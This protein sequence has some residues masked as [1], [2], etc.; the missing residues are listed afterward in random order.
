MLIGAVT[1][2]TSVTIAMQQDAE[3]PNLNQSSTDPL[4]LLKYKVGAAALFALKQSSKPA[5]FDFY[6]HQDGL[7]DL[8]LSDP[9]SRDDQED[10]RQW[11]LKV[12]VVGSVIANVFLLGLQLLAAILSK[13]L[14]LFATTADAFMD[15][16]SAVVLMIAQHYAAQENDLLY[17]TGKARYETAGIIVFATLMATLSIQIVV[18]SIQGFLAGQADIEFGTIAISCVTIAIGTKFILYMYCSALSQYSS[19]RILAQDHRNDILVNST[20]IVFGL[21]AK[22]YAWWV[23]PIGAILIAMIILR[24]WTLTGQGTGF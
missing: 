2:P 19:A 22:Y 10:S 16:A 5:I 9:C 23:D 11:R 8:L 20:G 7:I 21:I 15:L 4:S 14:A 13:S 17:P 1:S 24:S 6:K 3:S 12:A 18:T